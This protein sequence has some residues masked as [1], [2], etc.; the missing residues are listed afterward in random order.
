VS[1]ATTTIEGALEPLDW[2]RARALRATMPVSSYF[3]GR[4]TER[5]ALIGVASISLSLLGTALS[6]LWMLALGPILLGVPHLLA[7][8]RYCVARPGWHRNAALWVGVGLPLLA[9]GCGAGMAVGFAAVAGA[10]V[11]IE[12]RPLR[13]WLGVAV[14]G[15]GALACVLAGPTS[16]LVLL[17]LH[18]FVAVLLWWRWRERQSALVLLP[19]AAFIGASLLIAAGALD[20]IADMGLAPAAAELGL[21]HHLEALAPGLEGVAGLRLV[22]LF[23]FA[24]SVHYVIWLRMIPEEDRDRATPRSFKTSWRALQTELGSVIPWVAVALSVGLVGW[25]LV[26]LAAAR[27]DYLRL[28]RFHLFL[29]LCVLASLWVGGRG[30]VIPATAPHQR[31]RS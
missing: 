2:L 29:E 4:R 11:A 30:F 7:D 20:H 24:Q 1:A 31:T 6:P 18:N 10:C 27:A 17:H 14:A 28:A 16:T 5:V 9:V 25:A 12:G 13:R 23:T 26:D 19:L 8:L 15:A 21:A 22:L 3:A